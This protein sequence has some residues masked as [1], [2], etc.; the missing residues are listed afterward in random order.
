[1]ARYL[2]FAFW[3]I[4]F[5][6]EMNGKQIVKPEKFNF[7]EIKFNSVSK[8][9]IFDNFDESINNSEIKQIINYWFNNK[10]KTDGFDGSLS[11]VVKDIK[12]EEIKKN[13]YFKFLLSMKIEFI[14]KNDDL[15][16][17]K[18][19]TIKVSEYGDILGNFSINDQ[20]NLEINIIH[21]SLN[22]VSKKIKDLI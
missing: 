8:K 2:A 13:D 17:S 22:N 9:L 19:L 10:I 16:R 3:L 14:E 6:C 1:M 12:T 5:G 11:V 20:E 4:L 15:N 7:D 18:T 21:K